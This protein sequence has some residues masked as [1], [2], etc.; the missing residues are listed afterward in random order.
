MEDDTKVQIQNY[1]TTHKLTSKTSRAVKKT[2]TR[3]KIVHLLTAIGWIWSKHCSQH[4]SFFEQLCEENHE[5]TPPFTYL[6]IWWSIFSALPNKIKN[7]SIRY[8]VTNN[9]DRGMYLFSKPTRL[10]VVEV[11]AHPKHSHRLV[12]PATALPVSKASYM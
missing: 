4:S 10:L 6:N 9:W 11:T 8:T 3:N 7:D 12:V 2:I 1:S 5:N